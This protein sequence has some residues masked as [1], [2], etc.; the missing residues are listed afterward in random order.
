MNCLAFPNADWICPE[1]EVGLKPLDVLTA[2]HNSEPPDF[3]DS[4]KNR[5]FLFRRR[6]WLSLPALTDRK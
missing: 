2:A 5:H 1:C 3:P 6:F 4:L